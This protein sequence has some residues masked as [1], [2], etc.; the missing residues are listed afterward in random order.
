MKVGT[1]LDSLENGAC[2]GGRLDE[3]AGAVASHYVA[4]FGIDQDQLTQILLSALK[5]AG[6]ARVAAHAW[7]TEQASQEQ[8]FW[9]AQSEGSLIAEISRWLGQL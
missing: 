3:F 2:F 1:R 7:T 8:Q 4:A 9:A 5:D 6:D